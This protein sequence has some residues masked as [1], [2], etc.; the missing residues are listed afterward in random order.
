LSA[1][2][3]F[4]SQFDMLDESIMKRNEKA[5]MVAAK[6]L[7]PAVFDSVLRNFTADVPAGTSARPR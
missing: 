2:V 6:P 1:F 7:S 5:P 3:E 4:I